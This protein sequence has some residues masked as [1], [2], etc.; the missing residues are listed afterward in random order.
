[1]HYKNG[2]EVKL[3][4][5]VVGTGYNLKGVIVGTVVGL[6]PGQSSRNIR[7]AVPRTEVREDGK[8]ISGASGMYYRETYPSEGPS[9]MVT[10]YIEYGQT[11]AFL[12]AEDALKVAA[13]PDID[14]MVNAFLGWPLPS[15]VCPDPCASNPSYP[16]RIGTDLLTA[17][18]AK[19]MFE[20]CTN[21]PKT[22]SDSVSPS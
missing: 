21:V 13:N 22:S 1:M 10:P 16:H 9:V 17:S 3:G 6:V 19:Q 8:F 11:D 4:D 12:H 20:H 5:P 18:E 2:R 7:I 14:A 15:S